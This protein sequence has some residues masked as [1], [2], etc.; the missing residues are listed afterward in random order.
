MV[1]SSTTATSISTP[2]PTVTVPRISSRAGS[3]TRAPCAHS[4]R[5]ARRCQARSRCDSCQGSF[6][7]SASCASATSAISAGVY[8]WAA[9][10][11]TSV[12]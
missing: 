10:A 2:L 1:P 5:T 6:A 3:R 12:R 8:S 4:A 11:K 7:P 9:K